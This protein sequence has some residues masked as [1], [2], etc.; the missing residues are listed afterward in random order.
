MSTTAA[1][2]AAKKKKDRNRLLLILHLINLVYIWN[3]ND[4][5]PSD[6]KDVITIIAMTI[7]LLLR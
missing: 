3:M 6:S 5:K 2:A 7:T 1:A 4:K